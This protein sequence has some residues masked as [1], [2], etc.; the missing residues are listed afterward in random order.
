MII[1]PKSFSKVNISLKKKTP[2]INWDVGVKKSIILAGPIPINL[3]PSVNKN[4]GTKVI[5]P[6][7]N[8]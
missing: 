1:N 6:A 7:Q 4:R 8:R 3:K 5:K 2:K